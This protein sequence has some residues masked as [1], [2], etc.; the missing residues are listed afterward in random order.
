MLLSCLERPLMSNTPLHSILEV[1]EID[2]QI[3][4]VIEGNYHNALYLCSLFIFKWTGLGWKYFTTL[5][6]DCI[7]RVWEWFKLRMWRGRLRARLLSPS[8]SSCNLNI[9]FS[10]SIFDVSTIAV[11]S[12]IWDP[13]VL[14]YKMVV[15][16]CAKFPCIICECMVLRGESFQWRD[17]ARTAISFI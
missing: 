7:L 14:C 5:S 15:L 17:Y 9:K 8:R 4:C 3:S 2:M 16:I 6:L 11:K 13:L 12:R 1:K 10:S